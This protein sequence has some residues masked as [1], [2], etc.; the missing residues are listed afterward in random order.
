[1]D[2]VFPNLNILPFDTESGKICGKLKAQLEKKGIS[3]R[4]PDL[5]IAAIAIQYNMALVTGNI[6]R[7]KNISGLEVEDWIN[8]N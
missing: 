1:M 7:F 4:E 8:G 3:K 2:V 5:R 6:K